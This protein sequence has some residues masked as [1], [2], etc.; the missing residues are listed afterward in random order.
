[1]DLANS[2]TLRSPKPLLKAESWSA[3][4]SA[5]NLLFLLTLAALGRW[6]APGRDGRPAAGV[7]ARRAVAG[8]S[9][10]IRTFLAVERTVGGKR[11]FR[12]SPA[13]IERFRFTNAAISRRRS[14]RLRHDLVAGRVWAG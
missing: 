14:D 10:I 8:P 2:L 12:I 13:G 9:R 5:F 4:S 3:A 11:I 6:Q 1:M 7:F